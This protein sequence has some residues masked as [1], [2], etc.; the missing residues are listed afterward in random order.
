MSNY[1]TKSFNPIN[2]PAVPHDFTGDNNLGIHTSET[3]QR[4][5]Y[6]TRYITWDGRVYKYMLLTTG[7]CV[8]YHGV[9]NTL[10]AFTSWTTALVGTAG[11]REY[12]I[13]DD[14]ISEDQFAGAMIALY[15][16]TI[17]NTTQRHIIGND[18][19]AGTTTKLYLEAPLSAN[20]T[21]SDAV[22]V[23]ENPYRAVSEA[24]NSTAAWVG[25]P[26]VTAATTYNIWS[27]TWGPCLVSPGNT[28]LDDAAA[29]ER[30][31]QWKYN[32]TIC[33]IDDGDG[34]NAAGKG[35][36]AGYILNAGTSDI[37]GP[38]IFLMCST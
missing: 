15:K 26:C 1:F 17:D 22:E 21:A 12:T 18:A 10:E 36:T 28:T 16:S 4:Y 27:Q 34:Y 35:Q 31:V 14:G 13:T 11:D 38:Q 33:E 8:S 37:A 2:W 23:F 9:A 25:V 30:L 5:V 6:G 32:A 29:N 7:G 20:M 24:S 3:I 19:T